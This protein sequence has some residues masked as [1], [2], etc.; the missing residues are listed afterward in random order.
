MSHES[1]PLSR[2]CGRSVGAAP[3]SEAIVRSP[4]GSTRDT[5][6][7]VRSPSGPQ[8]STPRRA[9]SRSTIAPTSPPL[10]TATMRAPA[11]RSAAHAATFAACPPG[12]SVVCAV[13]SSP[14]ASGASSRTIT[15]RRR[16]PRVQT[17]IAYDPEPWKAIA[18]TAG[19]CVR[20]CTAPSSARRPPWQRRDA[21]GARSSGSLPR[22][23]PR[24][25]ARRASARRSS[26]RP[27]RTSAGRS[28]L[29]RPARGGEAAQ[30]EPALD[31][32]EVDVRVAEHQI[33]PEVLDGLPLE[34]ELAHRSGGFARAHD[35]ERPERAYLEARRASWVAQRDRQPRG[36]I[37]PVAR[38]EHPHAAAERL[39]RVVEHVQRELRVG[40][41]CDRAGE[42]VLALPRAQEKRVVAEQDVVGAPGVGEPLR[43]GLPGFDPT[44]LLALV[45]ER[46]PVIAPRELERREAED[47]DGE[48]RN[49]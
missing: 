15:S 31:R 25:R 37:V 38:V 4:P 35:E 44:A 5:T 17:S 46:R 45:Q 32:E 27:G 14:A 6:T 34:Q 24:S 40:A 48:G 18:G 22:G 43:G 2:S 49:A 28:R 42:V 12:A 19:A 1:H 23:S 13:E 10:R 8:T 3:R 26:A 36:E 11:P 47:H 33:L 41:R 30:A 9:S 16:S 29:P 20:S 7:P 21:A 39:R